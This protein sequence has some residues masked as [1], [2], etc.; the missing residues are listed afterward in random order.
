M[1]EPAHAS[2]PASAPGD[3]A[4]DRVARVVWDWRAAGDA[5]GAQVERRRQAAAARRGGLLRA[6]VG[7]VIGALVWLW[8]PV[9]GAVVLAI[10]VAL[11]VVALASPL[12]AHRAVTAALG[13]FGHA[14]GLAVTWVLMTLIFYLLFFPVGRAR[15]AL[16]RCGLTFGAER[17]RASYWEPAAWERVKAESYRRQ[18]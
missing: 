9:L 7:A 4:G 15:R 1:A 13:R 14:V 3:A 17:G 12:G 5:A 11:L 10:T 18:F 6:A 16:G 2:P 8:K